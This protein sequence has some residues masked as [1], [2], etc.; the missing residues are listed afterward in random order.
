[1]KT[2]SR[3]GAQGD[4]QEPPAQGTGSTGAL[5]AGKVFSSWVLGAAARLAQVTE[6]GKPWDSVCFGGNDL[7]IHFY[8]IKPERS[9]QNVSV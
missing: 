9:S 5:D 2:G 1:M 7:S 4:R 3:Q 6:D 8:L